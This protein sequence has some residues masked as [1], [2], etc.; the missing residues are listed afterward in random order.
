MSLKQV[1]IHPLDGER[2][3]Q[4]EKEQK[5]QDVVPTPEGSA[6]GPSL[7]FRDLVNRR[8]LTDLVESGFPRRLWSEILVDRAGFEPA[9]FRCFDLEWLANRTFFGPERL[10]L[11]VYQAELPAHVL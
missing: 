2:S 11:P 6:F 4:E 5:V 3:G 7:I 10:L 9:T 8:I 1:P